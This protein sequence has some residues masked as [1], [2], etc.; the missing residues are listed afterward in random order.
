MGD[1]STQFPGG[2]PA[3]GLP[4]WE[5]DDCDIGTEVLVQWLIDETAS[6]KA[7]GTIEK[8]AAQVAFEALI[9]L[10]KT[11]DGYGGYDYSV[12]LNVQQSL[13]AA[14]DD[15]DIAWISGAVL[16]SDYDTGT[17][18]LRLRATFASDNWTAQGI[19]VRVR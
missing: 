18:Y 2:A 8:G 5:N 1:H 19:S 4:S 9:H 6:Y 7:I 14:A 11:D 16:Y 12:G 15:D 10:L 13:L 3:T 17:G